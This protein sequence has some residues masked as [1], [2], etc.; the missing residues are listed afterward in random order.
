MLSKLNRTVRRSVVLLVLAAGAL[1][2]TAAPADAFTTVPGAWGAGARS[3]VLPNKCYS[4]NYLSGQF[5]PASVRVNEAPA[6]ANSDQLVG[7]WMTLS[8][9]DYNAGTWRVVNI[10]N[11]PTLFLAWNNIFSFNSSTTFYPPTITGLTKGWYSVK[12]QYS[13]WVSGVGYVGAATDVFNN[14]TYYR[15]IAASGGEYLNTTPS[16]VAQ[17]GMC[18][19]D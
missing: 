9:Y 7:A 15:M 13:W 8:T 12:F 1:S 16:S 11:S 18:Y 6:Y 17:V 2:A 3:Q 5:A 19:V 14:D 10:N 4:A